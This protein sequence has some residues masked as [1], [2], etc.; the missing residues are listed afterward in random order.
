MHMENDKLEI[1]E[2]YLNMSVEELREKKEELLLKRIVKELSEGFEQID[3]IESIPRRKVHF[4]FD[5]IPNMFMNECC[6]KLR[7][8][9]AI[10]DNVNLSELNSLFEQESHRKTNAISSLK[11]R[12]KYCKNP[13]EKRDLEQQL[14]KLYKERKK[15]D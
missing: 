11:K 7:E 12:I 8:L 13:M 10:Q 4:N 15:H 9:C 1:P 3:K 5:K 6:D 2:E 14:N